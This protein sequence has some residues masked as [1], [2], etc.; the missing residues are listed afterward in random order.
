MEVLLTRR[1]MREALVRTAVS[2][3][4]RTL[5]LEA[6]LL[7]AIFVIIR[8]ILIKPISGLGEVA[9][10]VAESRDYGLRAAQGGDD[11]IGRLI[12]SFNDM[13]A[14]I[15]SRDD[16][17]KEHSEKLEGLVDHRTAELVEANKRLMDLNGQLSSAK[18]VAEEANRHKSEFLANMSH[19][20]RT[21]MNAIIGMSDLTLVTKLDRKQ[22]EY[23]SI[24]RS[25]AR[26]LLALINDILDFSKI[27]AGRME[28]ESVPFTLRDVLE[29]VSDMF[30]EKV[31]E[32]EL[33]LVVDLAPD[34]PRRVV[35]DPLR[36]RQVLVNLTANAFKFTERGEVA[37][38]VRV[39]E[40]RGGEAV[41]EFTVQDTGVGIQE[42]AQKK[43]FQAFTQADGSTTRKY[44][45]TG[46]G[47]AICRRIVRLMGGEI[48]VES[49]PGRGSAFI[50]T[51]RAPVGPDTADHHLTLP[52][53]LRGMR[54]L[55]VDYNAAS[56]L[57]ME[58]ILCSFGFRAG[59]AE[60]AEEGLRL[61]EAARAEGDPVK[62]VVM[63]WRLPIMDGIEATEE[64]G[65]RWG[66]EAPRV[67]MLT[68]YGR[69][70][71]MVRARRAGV[72]SFLIK[73]VKQSLLFDTIMEIF[74]RAPVGRRPAL[75]EAV[76]AGLQGMRVLLVEDNAVNRRVAMEILTSAGVE[77]ACAVNGREAVERLRREACHVVLMDV[78]MP[79]MDGYAAT[80]AIRTELG[81]A[82]LPIIAMTAHAMQGDRQRCLEAGMNDYAPKPIDRKELFAAL[83]R[84]ARN[85]VPAP[86]AQPDPAHSQQGPGAAPAI[87]GLDTADG[88]KRLGGSVK[89]Y[90]DII[91]DFLAVNA[92]FPEKL[93]AALDQGD[94]REAVRLAHSLKGA[95]GN[96][97]AGELAERARELEA[98][99]VE[100]GAQAVGERLA[101]VVRLLGE[102]EAAMAEHLA[103]D[104]AADAAAPAAPP[105]TAG[106]LSEVLDSLE[107]ALADAD[108]AVSADLVE[109]LRAEKTGAG[110]RGQELQ[111]LLGSVK[112]QVSDYDFEAAADSFVRLR[113]V[114]E[115]G[116][117]Q[118]QAQAG[119]QGAG[120]AAPAA[121]QA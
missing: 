6:L 10:A 1:F 52:S 51:L 20:I 92:D 107:R 79:E 15:Q 94:A 98:A 95:A 19:E 38:R 58:R 85:F 69:E 113:I 60:S 118:A 97:A 93:Q 82:D 42:E 22:R 91:R 9:D 53:D 112:R 110:E 88:L 102:L 33:E 68:A 86:Q 37:I 23:V 36:L 67:I 4:V 11:E 5:V 59:Q 64:V 80:R 25:S 78:Q 8:R 56:R 75:D 71:E 44:G 61:L 54:V 105:R 14:Q 47:L 18:A 109:S 111:K 103:G 83:R 100:G 29:E 114:L 76:E 39:L 45:G 96:I 35:S 3:A 16:Q 90:L 17:L 121:E 77:A 31:A 49:E 32:K 72:D 70:S 27:E 24:I 26:S 13:L 119:T 41:L 48:R 74:G 117:A 115:G 65:R 40:R 12:D 50:F 7:L 99:C 66:E 106:E 46:L 63:D 116:A 43:L 34:A 62:L 55:A 108:P 120:F 2:A 87:P 73:P 89:L 81:L 30:L 104:P 84:N 21:P 57:V 28:L 101:A